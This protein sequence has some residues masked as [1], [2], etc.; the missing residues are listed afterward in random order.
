M[1]K[2]NHSDTLSQLRQLMR[3]HHV[4]YYYVPT[5]DDHN[6]EYVPPYWQRRDWLTGFTG[7]YGQALIGLD[8][9]YLWTDPRYYLQANAELDQQYFQMM[10]Q[11]AGVAAPINQWLFENAQNSV[12]A[13]DPKVM[14][15]NERNQWAASLA[16]VGSELKP[17][18][19][20]LVDEVWKERPDLMLSECQ[21]LPEKYTGMRAIDKIAQIR[22]LMKKEGANSLVVSML[23]E[24]AWLYNVRANDVPFNPLLISYAIVTENEAFLF[25]A[26]SR[27]PKTAMPYFSDEKITV[28]PYEEFE[29]ALHSLNDTVWVDPATTSWWIAN[30]LTQARLIEKTS[31]IVMMKAIKNKTELEGTREAHRLDGLAVVKFFHWLENNWKNGVTEVTAA[32]QLEAFRR[33]DDRCVDLS[34][35]TICGFADHGAIVHYRAEPDT[36]HTITDKNLLL[37]DSGGQ[38]FEGTTDVTR[39]IHLAEP[40]D[41]QKKHY[42]LVLKGHLALRHAVF[43]DGICGEHLNPIA[44]MPL[45]AEGMDF[46]HGTGHGVGAYLCVHEGPQRISYATTHVPLKP[47][48][49]VSNEP[50]VYFDGEYGIRIENLCEITEAVSKESSPT[51]HGP[52]YTL[53]DLTLIPYARELIDVDLLAPQEIDWVN[54]YHSQVYQQLAGD[55]PDDV[56]E[57]LKK[58]TAPLD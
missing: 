26:L 48:M 31:P 39:T 47:G 2:I 24:V 27:I 33:E 9:A 3:D 8:K 53:K 11:V 50:G 35:P 32:D 15:I 41:V 30:A 25:T 42:T 51:D 37:V 23:D 12:V 22:A 6:N 49:I 54:E 46:G 7:S 18:A 13:V 45:W 43:P 29:S 20:N 4:D 1:V 17:V 40:T 44:R 21:I 57:W 16:K 58:A 38:Y 36:A 14:S 52:F 56:R 10:K 34:F 5:R 55:L 19:D 28:R